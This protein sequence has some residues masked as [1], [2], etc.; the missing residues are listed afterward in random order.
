MTDTPKTD[1]EIS[2]ELD[3]LA[4]IIRRAERDLAD[5]KMLSIG[6]LPERTQAVCNKVTELPPEEGREYKT[7]LGALV[8]ELDRLEAG[9]SARREELNERLAGVDL[10]DDPGDASGQP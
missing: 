2:Q 3:A 4:A 6:G 5:N 7:R 8:S 1:P 9:I 10:P